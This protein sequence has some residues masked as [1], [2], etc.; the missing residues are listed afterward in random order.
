MG[1]LISAVT[2]WVVHNP[3]WTDA[4]LAA[5]ILIQGE[6]TIILGTY[7]VIGGSITWGQFFTMTLAALFLGETTVYL[8]GRIVR[9]TR[10]GWRL[11]RKKKDDRRIQFY[12][13]HMKRNMGRLFM[14]GK[15]VPA[16][17][18]ILLFLA[19][20]TRTR[21]AEYFRAYVKS[22]LLWFSV[23]TALAYFTMSGVHYLK[24]TNIFR[25]TEIAIVVILA[26]LFGG[27]YALKKLLGKYAQTE[28]GAR[29][30]GDAVEEEFGK[31]TDDRK[32]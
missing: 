32:S 30:I 5:G 13:Y 16:T 7:L 4:I 3:A 11:Y 17:N 9:T 14:I 31:G 26:V 6:L 27:E 23:I 22:A 29:A 18:I 1:N 28:E 2:T 24:A 15:F 8:I 12:T 10:F 21:F 19:G 25:N 20:W